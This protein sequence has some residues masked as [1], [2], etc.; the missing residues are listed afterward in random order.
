[1][2]GPFD[3]F[4]KSIGE[5]SEAIYTAFGMSIFGAII[6]ALSTLPGGEMV[7]QYLVLFLSLMAVA[8]AVVILGATQEALEAPLGYIIGR[9]LG[10]WLMI[11]IGRI[12]GVSM[13]VYIISFLILLT[14]GAIKLFLITCEEAPVL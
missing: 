7:V 10:L 3:G 1:M 8:D 6:S 11:H 12:L 4:D 13:K 14:F 5:G 9:A 2:A